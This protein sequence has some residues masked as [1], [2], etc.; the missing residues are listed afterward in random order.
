M[1]VQKAEETAMTPV[2]A[3]VS[4]RLVHAKDLMTVVIDFINGPWPEPEP[5]HHHR[6]EQTTYVAEGEVRFICEDE[7]EQ[8]LKAGDLFWVP[9]GKKHGIQLLSRN[10]RLIDSFHPIREDFI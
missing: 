5:L 7:E 9:A 3:G 1:P 6:H 2:K 4:R 10:A 8:I